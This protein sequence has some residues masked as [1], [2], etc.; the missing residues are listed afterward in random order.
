MASIFFVFL[1]SALISGI[2]LGLTFIL[3][4][5]NS[6][7]A[8]FF[9]GAVPCLLVL[10][11]GVICYVISLRLGCVELFWSIG[12]N[13]PGAIVGRALRVL[14]VQLGCAGGLASACVFLARAF[15]TDEAA[16]YMLPSSSAPVSAGPQSQPILEGQPVLEGRPIPKG[17]EWKAISSGKY[18][19]SVVHI[20][21]EID[22]V[23]T[24]SKLGRLNG[25][26]LFLKSYVFGGVIQPHYT[27]DIQEELDQT[28]ED[29]LPA[30]L[31]FLRRR[32]LERFRIPIE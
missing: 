24:L 19:A 27:R 15:L 21:G 25:T 20:P 6:A 31:E 16:S 28:D 14:L 9:R 22:D 12:S 1:L 30:K 26:L 2:F 29:S 8:L 17:Q 4:D 7:R 23:S 32:E 13:Y 3:E 10:I 18:C 11:I 5:K